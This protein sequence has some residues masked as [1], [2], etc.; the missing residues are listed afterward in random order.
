VVVTTTVL[1][2][3]CSAFGTASGSEPVEADA[4]GDAPDAAVT[5]EGEGGGVGCDRTAPFTSI[6]PLAEVNTAEHEAFPRVSPD[7]RTI[8]FERREA[9]DQAPTIFRATRARVGD[10]FGPPAPVGG[11]TS[12]GEP[13]VTAD[14]L[15]I[16]FVRT[17]AVGA[18]TSKISRPALSYARRA[19]VDAPFGSAALHPADSGDHTIHRF[20]P[21]VSSDGT[22]LFFSQ[23]QGASDEDLFRV[24][25]TASGTVAST[26]RLAS[27]AGAGRDTAPVLSSDGLTLYFYSERQT[28]PGTGTIWVAHR[29]TPGGTFGAPSRVEDLAVDGAYTFP[30]SVS[31]D[32]C[33]LYFS[34][35]REGGHGDLYVAERSPR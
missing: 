25:L 20:A 12:W 4:G 5:T 27:L 24:E 30:G 16:L 1:V 22:E 3:A 9:P 23:T 10:D 18:A 8:Y 11:T 32:G 13:F 35:N 19:A 34:S 21:F 6:R 31:V 14:G 17:V 2:G 7:E 29:D 28:A 15:E 33:R 26:E